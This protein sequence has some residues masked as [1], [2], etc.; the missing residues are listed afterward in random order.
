MER[1]LS[2]EEYTELLPLISAEKRGRID[3]MR[4]F[5]DRQRALLGELLVRAE[6]SR[7]L[8]LGDRGVI[9]SSDAN[10]K[11]QLTEFPDIHFNVSHSGRY[12]VCAFGDAPVGVD[13]EAIRPADMRIVERFF[14]KLEREYIFGQVSDE[15]R[16]RAFYRVWTMKEAYI[17]ME[18]RG[19]GIPLLSFDVFD[20]DGACFIELPCGG[21]AVCHCCASSPYEPHITR[22]SVADITSEFIR[23]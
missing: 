9:I 23:C 19:L 3:R 5:I 22:L 7:S 13:V 2:R 21:D 18:G 15:A 1:E 16:L 10:G 12:V 4:R 6:I 17:K 14:A 20:M 8:P 11:P